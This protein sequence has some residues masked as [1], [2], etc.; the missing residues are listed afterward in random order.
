M[1]NRKI[2][3]VT[4]ASSDVGCAL[5]K[6]V[7]NNYDKVWVHYRDSSDR[8]RDLESWSKNKIVP[9][10]ADFLDSNSINELISTITESGDCPNHI[11]HLS[12]QRIHALQFHKH[13]W[14]DFQKEIDISLRSI[15]KILKA[16]IPKMSKNNYGKII[17]M[18][19]AYLGQVSPKYFSPYITVK[20]SLLGLMQILAAE[21]VSNGI[22]VNA[23]SP[24]MMDTRF[25][26][27]LPELIIE[28]SI[29]D[30][31]L[32]RILTVNEVIP[33]IEYLLSSACD[34][35]TGQNIFISGG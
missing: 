25:L 3:L 20:Y 33:T 6:Q 9:I 26:S 21:Y 29:K 34:A 17:F 18:L 14:D 22:T 32:G 2:L 16:F 35:V 10:Q 31:P 13:T 19:S 23:I 4:G 5:V 1:H 30:N 12:A 27:N 7:V 24:N 8:I 11:V 15:I 28:Q